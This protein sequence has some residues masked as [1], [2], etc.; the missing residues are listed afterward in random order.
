MTIPAVE[1][2]ERDPELRGYP[3]TA[4]KAMLTVLD[5]QEFRP[6]KQLWLTS[7]LRCSEKTVERAIGKLIERGYLE[8][9]PVVPTEARTYRLRFSRS[10]SAVG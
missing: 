7:E 4:L 1:A 5:I 9:G 2:A 8:R 6:V 3:I 10:T